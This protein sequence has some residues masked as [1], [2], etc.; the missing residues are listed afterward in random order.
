MTDVPYLPMNSA[1]GPA[2]VTAGPG[3]LTVELRLPWY[4]AL[5]VSTV[6]IEAVEIDGVPV[7]PARVTFTLEGR[8]YALAAMEEATD[9]SWYVLDSAW[10]TIA[11]ALPAAG[12]HTLAVTLTTYPPYIH[13]LKRPLRDTCDFALGQEIAHV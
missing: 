4:R 5:P 9:H 1:I 8:S 3:G 12:D 6:E 13:G 7:D 2:G 11:G 10:L